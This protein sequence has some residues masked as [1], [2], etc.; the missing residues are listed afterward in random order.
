MDLLEDPAIQTEVLKQEGRPVRGRV[1]EAINRVERLNPTE[2]PIYSELLDGTWQV[3]YSSSY[4]PGLLSS[5]TRELAF[6]LYS[7][8]FSLGNALSSFANG[9]WG[10][11][12]G[13]QVDG[14]TVRIS[15]G[16]TVE[17]S[18]DVE[19]AGRRETLSYKAEL[20]PLSEMRMSEEVLELQLP[21]PLG[22]QPPPVELRRGLLVTYLD[23]DMM[24]VR[25]ESGS[26]EVLKRELVPVMPST[27]TF[28]AAEAKDSDTPAADNSTASAA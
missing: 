10:Q 21:S 8:G 16:R 4:A 9:Y 24:I 27:V 3:K 18:L 11:S 22:D 5:P 1:D 23:E 12:L 19:V 13:V 15:D 14:K 28:S 17:A 2:E 7:G 25:D 6:F 20:L 26:P